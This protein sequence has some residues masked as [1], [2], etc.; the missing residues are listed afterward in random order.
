MVWPF[1]KS[2][3]AWLSLLQLDNVA[4]WRTVFMPPKRQNVGHVLFCFFDNGEA[5]FHPTKLW[6]ANFIKPNIKTPSYSFQGN[7]SNLTSM[8]IF[9][10]LLHYIK[11][12]LSI[13]CNGQVWLLQPYYG[14]LNIDHIAFEGFGWMVSRTCFV[15]GVFKW[16][17][18]STWL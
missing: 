6:E 9:A 13:Y 10:S 11:L 5:K 16:L 1:F 17:P 8:C 3:I 18:W 2:T 4:M 7:V 12:H 14:L 15:L